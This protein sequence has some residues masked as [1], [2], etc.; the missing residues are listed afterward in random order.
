M[1][2]PSTSVART[3]LIGVSV[4]LLAAWLAPDLGKTGGALASG[5]V[6]KLGIIAIFF[7]QG[8]ALPTEEFGRSLGQWRLHLFVQ[9]FCFL[10]VPLLTWALLKTVGSAMPPDLALGFLFLAILP[11]TIS[12]AAVMVGLAEGDLPS[13]VFNTALA[14]LIGV[15]SVPIAAGWILSSNS[16]VDIPV[17]PLLAKV[18]LLLAVPL[19]LGQL[20]RRWL[21]GW[22]ARQKKRITLFSN[23]VIFFLI[24]AAFS[25]AFAKGSLDAAPGGETLAWGI[26]GSLILL[27]CVTALAW[28]LARRFSRPQRIT[29]LYCS[30]QKTLAAGLPLAGAIYAVGDISALPPLSTFVLPLICFHPLQL[31]LGGVLAGRLADSPKTL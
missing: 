23:L 9:G 21:K 29:A 14:N 6:S 22:A 16:A 27:A 20:A 28:L 7:F 3:F 18:A 19:L 31:I 15:I 30:S 26:G 25:N 2:T 17:M 4:A 5:T 11:T 12:S 13:A 24:Y 1:P 10:M 8:V